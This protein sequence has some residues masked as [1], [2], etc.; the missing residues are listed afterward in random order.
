MIVE[1]ININKC[2][3]NRKVLED[4]SLNLKKGQIT[5]L[6]G[7]NGSGKTTLL[8]ILA[9]IYSADSGKFK[10]DGNS[11]AINP[12]TIEKIAYLPD[13]FDYFNYDKIKEIPGYYKIIYPR[14]DE[15]FFTEEISKYDY[16][17][18]QNVRN[19][20][21]GEKNLLGLITIIATNAEVLLV[22][23][24]LDGMDVIN[25]RHIIEYLLD[26]RDKDCAVFASS[27]ELAGLSGICDE[28]LYLSKEGHLT[29]TNADENKN[30]NK[31]QIVVKKDLPGEIRSR[32]VIISHIGRV[33]NI[34]IDM[35]EKDLL[36]LLDSPEIVQYDRLEMKVE[37][38]FYLEEGA[39]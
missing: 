23:E 28:I 39:K 26:A 15:K 22:D 2:F 20:S 5:G 24:I 3:D 4:V 21:K 16:N 31:I 7:R 9:G 8:K 11:L 37:D 12:R 6:V 33:Y 36:K 17:L 32:S 19:L 35:E 13:R 25:K 38:Y 18:N 10:I 30:I 14:F 27:H 34:L 1:A 29:T